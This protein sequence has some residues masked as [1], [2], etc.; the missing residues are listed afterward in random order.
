MATLKGPRQL[1]EIRLKRVIYGRR[2][3]PPRKGAP[4]LLSERRCKRESGSLVTGLC[5]WNRLG[6]QRCRRDWVRG[7]RSSA[8]G[9][10]MPGGTSSLHRLAGPEDHPDQALLYSAA[11]SRLK[12]F[13]VCFWYTLRLLI[14]ASRDSDHLRPREVVGHV[15]HRHAAVLPESWQTIGREHLRRELG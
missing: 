11:H 10:R 13:A 15:L 14:F 8:V 9:P 4:G 5:G 12:D 6:Q 2:D 7:E 1:N 3:E